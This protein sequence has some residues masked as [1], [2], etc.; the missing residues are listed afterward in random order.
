MKKIVV[1]L[2]ALFLSGS[3]FSFQGSVD[4]KEELQLVEEKEINPAA[5][6]VPDRCIVPVTVRK[7]GSGWYVTTYKG[8]P[9]MYLDKKAKEGWKNPK[10]GKNI[11]IMVSKTGQVVGWKVI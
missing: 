3:F 8:G 2:G 7:S 5:I 6:F 9:E 4:A 10:V 1:V 11:D